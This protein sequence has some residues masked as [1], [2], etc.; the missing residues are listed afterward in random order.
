MNSLYI[1][2]VMLALALVTY[3][4]FTGGFKEW[5]PWFLRLKARVKAAPPPLP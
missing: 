5:R 3:F 1:D 2:I 4:L